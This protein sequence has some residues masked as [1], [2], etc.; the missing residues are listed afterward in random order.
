MRRLFR[1]ICR[2]GH[3]KRTESILMNKADHLRESEVA[4]GARSR[5]QAEGERRRVAADRLATAIDDFIEWRMFAYWVRLIAEKR[6]TPEIEA[7]LRHKCPGFLERFAEYREAH[8]DD[9]EFLWL[10]L[11]DW[12]DSHCFDDALSQG[13]QHALG[14]YAARDQRLDRIRAYWQECDEQW[15]SQ[16]PARFPEY[17]DWRRA[18]LAER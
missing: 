18:A 10:Q 14:Y 7:T 5:H 2:Y 9:R 15:Q 8:R 6:V 3:W 4:L 1:K 13:W 12:I 11:I 17:E 16:L